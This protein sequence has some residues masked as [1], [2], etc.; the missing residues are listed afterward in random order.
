ML[1]LHI[2]QA[3]F[4]DSLILEYGNT[5]S[6]FILIDGGPPKNYTDSLRSELIDIVGEGGELELVAISHVDDDHIKGI[7]DLFVELKKQKDTNAEPLLTIHGLWHNTFSGTVDTQGNIA[8]R[9]NAILGTL[10]QNGINAESAGIVLD[11]IKDGNKVSVI[12][13][14]L[15]IEINAEAPNGL[16]TLEKSKEPII[17]DNLKFLILGPTQD[18]LDQL[19]IKW[20]EWLAKQ[21]ENIENGQFNIA[22]MTDKSVPNLSSIVF[23]ATAD[24]KTILFTGDSRG[25]FI[26][27]GL[28]KRKLLKNGQM[29]ID[30]LKVPHHGS[31]R[32]INREF[33]ENITADTYVISANGKYNNPDYATLT[34]IVD[35][36]HDQNRKIKLIITNETTSTKKLLN[37]YS[38]D[39]YNYSVQ[40]IK[41]GKNSIKIKLS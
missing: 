21:E 36:A 37:D 4:G 2:I 35:A 8:N 33:F 34:W 15:G 40:Y 20:D 27:E 24:D 31:D 17:F 26:Y 5:K 12:A 9:L 28:K 41:P 19:K 11:G 13:T 1:N 25:D 23:L 16:F 39:D 38:T 7:V 6:K 18:N 14:D 3:Q 32:N 30:I 29:H 22:S 10:S